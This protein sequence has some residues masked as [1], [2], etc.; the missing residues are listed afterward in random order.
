VYVVEYL[1]ILDFHSFFRINAAFTSL[2]LNHPRLAAAIRHIDARNLRLPASLISDMLESAVQ[3][4]VPLTSLDLC[5]N[6]FRG[7]CLELIQS[8]PTLTD[9][10]VSDCFLSE[11]G[12][13][14]LLRHCPNLRSLSARSGTFTGWQLISNFPRQE[15]QSIERHFPPCAPLIPRVEDVSY[16]AHNRPAPLEMRWPV[17]ERV[18]LSDSFITDPCLLALLKQPR[19]RSLQLNGC[20]RL[21]SYSLQRLLS[22][23][24]RFDELELS[25][26]AVS[27][28][29]LA[30]S[31]TPLALRLLNLAYNKPNVTL[32]GLQR[33]LSPTLRVLDLA[34]LSLGDDAAA[35]ISQQCPNLV[36]LDLSGNAIGDAGLRSINK[37]L[38]NLQELWLGGTRIS[39][40]SVQDLTLPCLITLDVSN[41]AVPADLPPLDD[42]ACVSAVM[43]CSRLHK[44][45]LSAAAITER[46][47]DRLLTHPSLQYIDAFCAFV[48]RS[49]QYLRRMPVTHLEYSQ[50]GA[51]EVSSDAWHA[52][53][54][55]GQPHRLSRVSDGASD[56]PG[57]HLPPAA[58]LHGHAASHGDFLTESDARS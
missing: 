30:Q 28:F 15:Q 23:A 29:D 12:F 21:S 55:T 41:I 45:D 53:T 6:Y 4:G 25:R 46:G 20:Q 16:Q 22:R 11:T 38:R 44:V 54:P 52:V 10:D 33:L 35:S 50:T 8:I 43:S 56:S 49:K 5:G 14:L 31:P 7:D 42:T 27:D 17:L 57:Q 36:Q 37:H 13:S 2:C 19:L 51:R 3:R 24:G 40:A 39:G 18:D 32:L 58:P 47:I 34:W 26:T 9:V 48:P 1:E